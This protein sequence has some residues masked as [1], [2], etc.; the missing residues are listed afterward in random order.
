MP[1]MPGSALPRTVG[2]YEILEE[3]EHDATT[4]T[5][6]A[7]DPQVDRAVV[8]R[9]V[10][11]PPDCPEGEREAFEAR[12][13][14]EA[15]RA[16][17]LVHPALVA[18]HDCG[19][20]PGTGALFVVQEDVM[21]TP[22]ERTFVPG[23][24][25][26]W[27]EALRVVGQVG[28]G[29]Q[30]LHEAGIVHQQ[31]RPGR[32]LLVDSRT[33]KLA[34]P[35]LPRPGTSH[36]SQTGMAT[37]Q[38]AA[39]LYVSPEQAVGER[40]DARSDI[41][42]LGALAYRLLTGHDAFEADAT[43]RILARVLHDRPAPPS[44]WVAGVPAGVDSVLA[45]ALAKA[46][47]D[48][49]ANA[50]IFCD[51]IDDLLAGRPP[52]NATAVPGE[53]DTWRV[54]PAT[55]ATGIGEATGT[56]SRRFDRRPVVRG[57]VG[58]FALA[59]VLGLELLRRRLEAPATPPAGPPVPDAPR[60][61]EASSGARS[62]PDLPSLEPPPSARLSIDFRH[63][64]ESGTLVVRVDG[65]TVLERRVSGAVTRRFL[66]IRL[67]EGSLHQVLDLPPGRHAISVR[68]R[69]G[70]EERSDTISGDFAA[71]STRKLSARVG[72]IGRRL[73]VEWQ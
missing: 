21:G 14:A 1:A 28:R 62:A 48:R 65:A 19:K 47:K 35:G 71:G 22:L 9:A 56:G 54:L 57:L 53:A 13:L 11:L 39:A 68:V 2:R 45:R 67:R 49:Y 60:L 12:F 36:P 31:V 15:R 30:S 70:D 46:R 4:V 7:R 25:R 58:L 3:V 64:L 24:P 61:P 40:L 18:T 37:A 17:L 72:R 16:C 27:R 26:P 33:C 10:V 66:G 73:S 38:G 51:D 20:D 34:G 23:E 32:I 6:R 63:T 43:G 59:L 41:F 8:V 5:Y 52:R 55:A 44:G 42:A 69:W 50:G 29:L